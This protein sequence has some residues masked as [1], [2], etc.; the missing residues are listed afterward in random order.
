MSQTAKSQ[1]MMNDESLRIHY[2][3]DSVVIIGGYGTF[4]SEIYID[5]G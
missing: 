4:Q 1:K 5:D 2:K 3:L